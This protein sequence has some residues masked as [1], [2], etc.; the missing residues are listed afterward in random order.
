[1]CDSLET[2]YIEE[3]YLH[4]YFNTFYQKQASRKCEKIFPKIEYLEGN[5]Q[6]SFQLKS[7]NA[8][9]IIARSSSQG[10]VTIFS[11]IED[12][13]TLLVVNVARKT[14]CSNFLKIMHFQSLPVKPQS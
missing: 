2:D 10:N 1:M 7:C 8:Q 6:N 12:V 4:A 11:K 3:T 9:Y 5:M 14:C 13:A